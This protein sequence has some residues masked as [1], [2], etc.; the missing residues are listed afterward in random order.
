MKSIQD[1]KTDEASAP[2]EDAVSHEVVLKETHPAPEPREY[3][4]ADGTA[5]IE[6]AFVKSSIEDEM[7]EEFDSW[8]NFVKKPK[9]SKTKAIHDGIKLA[10]SVTKVANKALNMA[11]RFFADHAI[12]LGLICLRL[13]EL[14][15]DSETPWGEW[16]KH[17]LPF[18]GKRNREKYMAIA[19]RSDV[20]RLSFLGVDRLETICSATKH[21]EEK[22]AVSKLLRKYNIAFDETSEVNLAEFK[23]MVDAA[24]NCEKLSRE[25]LVIEHALAISLTRSGVSFD[26]AFIRKLKDIRACGGQPLQYLERLAINGGKEA[27][28]EDPEKQVKDFNTLS[29]RLIKTVEFIIGNTEQLEKL[30]RQTF[31]DLLEKLLVLQKAANFLDED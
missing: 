9:F 24:L 2:K 8:M 11:A 25:S 6:I 28:E 16:A 26:K 14:N 23:V 1:E 22:D 30:H 13:K 19:K 12:I 3:M 17:N 31:D 20:H 15:K 7:K 27:N 21:S 4:G 5:V 10:A 18:L 29:S